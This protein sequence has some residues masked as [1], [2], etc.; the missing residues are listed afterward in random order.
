MPF[1]VITWLGFGIWALVLE[2]QYLGL[3]WLIVSLVVLPI[4]FFLPLYVGITGGGWTMALVTYGGG[5][6]GTVFFG[7]AMSLAPKDN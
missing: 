7:I 5:L 2:F 6:V 1:A 4:S 3:F